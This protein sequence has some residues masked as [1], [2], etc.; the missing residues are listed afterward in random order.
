MACLQSRC[1]TVELA[2]LVAPAV[3]EVVDGC[4]DAY[5]CLLYRADDEIRTRNSLGL[6]QEPLPFGSRQH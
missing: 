4:V 2:P 1:S 5:R 6:S 3:Y